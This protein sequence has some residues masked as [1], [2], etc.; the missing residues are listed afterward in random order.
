VNPV[1]RGDL[2][3]RLGS[4]E[5]IRAQTVY[6]AVCSTF[7]LL[8][9]PPE[10]GRFDL[11]DINLLLAT[12]AVQCV[13]VTYLSS[14]T[15]SSE[16]ALDGER[17]LPDLALSTFPPRVVALGKWQSSALY[18]CYLVAVGLPLFALT[19]VLRGVSLA[20]VFW[21]SVL[22]IAVATAAG[23]WGAWL[24]GRFASDFT[25]SLVHWLLLVAVFG[26][27][28]LLPP[29]WGPAN[30]IRLIEALIRDGWT[31]WLLVAVAGY[32]LLAAVGTSL[33]RRYIAWARAHGGEV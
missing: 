29:A 24:S 20:P 28:A 8:A 19:T 2:R 13:A 32:T 6:L 3:A 10:I 31:S 14:A 33:I 7:L 16:L 30:P 17:A 18:A 25:R 23:V 11:R 1:T 12:F 5:G 15:A 22:T 4:V 26:G 27:T 21:S 9:L